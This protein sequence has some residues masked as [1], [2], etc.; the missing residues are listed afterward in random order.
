MSIKDRAENLQSE[1][2]DSAQKIW[3]AGLGA[4]SMAGEEG[5]KLFKTLIEKGQEF[6]SRQTAAPVDAVKTGIG[7]AKERV[8]DVWGRVESLINERIGQ[9]F[10]TFGVPTRDEIA[11]LTNRVDALMDALNKLNAEKAPEATEEETKA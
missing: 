10:Q 5:N 3:L 4:M 9:A 2:K 1:V 6:E 11:D 7:S 8:E